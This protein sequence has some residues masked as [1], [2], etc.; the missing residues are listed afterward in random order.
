MFSVSRTLHTLHTR[1]DARTYAGTVAGAHICYPNDDSLS[2]TNYIANFR[3]FGR[4]NKPT[5]GRTNY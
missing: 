5:I 3:S 1:A 4:T 2:W